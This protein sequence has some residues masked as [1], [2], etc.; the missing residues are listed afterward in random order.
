[1]SD[2]TQAITTPTQ[3]TQTSQAPAE[4]NNSGQAPQTKTETQ[5]AV[6]EAA[7]EAMRRLKIDDQEIDE[8]EVIKVYRE[9]K[10]HQQAANKILQEG[11]SAKKQAELFV[12]MLRD[13]S[14]ILD[15]LRKVGHDDKTIR[16]LSESYLGEKIKYELMDERDRENLE[17]KQ[18]LQYFEDM[19]KKQKEEIQKRRDDE[20]RKKYS[21]Q[22]TK[23]F[24]EVLQKERVPANKHTVA[25]MAKY[26]HRAA[27]IGFEMTPAEAAKLVRED[28]EGRQRAIYGDADAETLIKFL[29]E[30]LVK[31][32][33]EHDVAKLKDPN[34]L[35][36]TPTE[37]SEIDIVRQKR[38]EAKRMTP[39]EW[40]KYNRGR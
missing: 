14:K 36:K 8:E 28:I 34:A 27:K 12:N 30:D 29:G 3:N 33:R 5:Q 4:P 11:K 19:E 23:E 32:I 40:R 21:E 37:Q 39:Q 1:M 7:K 35:L 13:K 18:K 24:T 9:R 38:G 22:Y 25:E 15:V 20:M 10:G 6:G 31:K 2:A 16:E 26:I 17:L